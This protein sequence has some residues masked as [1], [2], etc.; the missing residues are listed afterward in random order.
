M[1]RAASFAKALRRLAELSSVRYDRRGYGRSIG[2]GVAEG[3]SG[4]V[5][6]L[7]AVVTSTQNLAC[8]VVVVGHSFG[9]VLALA[10]ADRRPD[11]IG[12]VGAFEAPMPWLSQWPSRTAGGSAVDA[13][14]TGGPEEAAEQFMRRMIGDQ[15]WERLPAST[16]H[17]RRAEGSALVAELSAMRSPG[18]P[19]YDLETL[20][21]PVI[22]GHG[23]LSR[24]HHVEA[25]QRLARAAHTN[26]LVIEGASHSAHYTHPTEFAQFVERAIAAA[27]RG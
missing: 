23:S 7:L 10:A 2:A 11:L 3:A 21:V 19:P 27:E 26:V 16:R 5:D 20:K 1:D 13:A 24:P 9:G 17:T 4:H 8:P 15:R 25:A 12:A 6:D 18:L 22:A 14:R